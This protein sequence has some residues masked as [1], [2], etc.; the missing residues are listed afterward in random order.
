MILGQRRSRVV[1][2]I[3]AMVG[4]GFLAAGVVLWVDARRLSFEL[5][6]AVLAFVLA[7]AWWRQRAV[8][9]RWGIR[10]VHAFRENRL[11]WAGIDHVE[12]RRP[13]WFRAALVLVPKGGR[14]PISVPASAGLQRR[15]RDRMVEL[16]TDL[17]R[18]HGFAVMMPNAAQ[19]GAV[20]ATA[21]SGASRPRT[22]PRA[23]PV[24]KASHSDVDGDGDGGDQGREAPATTEVDGVDRDRAPARGNPGAGWLALLEPIEPDTR[25]ADAADGPTSN[26]PP[27]PTTEEPVTA[28]SAGGDEPER[29]DPALS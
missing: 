25:P 27:R 1:A 22:P 5:P 28:R 20:A 26:G 4:L 14:P 13:S 9:D 19:D 24:P 15:Q 2:T 3:W 12:I 10:T 8:V 7:L 16:L 21:G 11:L 29:D 17:S 6:A 18:Q 23:V